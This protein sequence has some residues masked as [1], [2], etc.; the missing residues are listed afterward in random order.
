MFSATPSSTQAGG[1]PNLTVS[2]TRTGSDTE[3]L[4]DL[5]ID[6]PPGVIGNPEA[7]Q[8]CSRADFMADACPAASQVGTASTVADA[9]GLNLPTVPGSVYVL[10]PDPTEAAALGIV[11]RPPASDLGAISKVFLVNSASAHRLPNGDYALRNVS[12]NLPRQVFLLGLIPVDITVNSLTLTLNAAGDGPGKFFVTNTTNCGPEVAS[13]TAVDYN[14]QSVSKDAPYQATGCNSVPFTPGMAMSWSSTRTGALT[15]PNLTLTVPGNESPIRQSH[16]KAVTVRF[17]ASVTLDAFSALAIDT[18]SQSDFDSDSCAAGSDL[19]DALAS[20]PPLP[21]AFTGDVYRLQAQ[22]GEAFG[23][24]LWLRGP[25]GLKANLRGFS[26]IENNRIVTTFPFQPQIPFTQFTLK[27]TRNIFVN[28]GNC[29][30]ITTDATLTGWSGA[31]ANVSADT[32]VTGCEHPRSASVLN[33]PMVPNFRQ[34]ISASQC[35]ARGGTASTHGAPL[36]LASCNP[37]GYAPGTAAHQGPSSVG[38]AQYVFIPGNPDEGVDPD[39]AIGLNVSDVQDRQTGADYAPNASGPDVSLVSK[40]RITDFLN[41]PQLIDQATASD[42]DFPVP[43]ECTPTADPSVGSSCNVATSANATVF[44]SI[45][46]GA[47]TMMQMF[48]VRLNDSGSNG[49]LGDGDDRA[50]S[51]QGLYVR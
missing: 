31:V 34:T 26:T 6:L 38:S 13:V 46:S 47:A 18:C 15:A 49:V 20:V 51:Q 8:K 33:V 3:D 25:R 30:P 28:P 35:A 1:H 17:P 4:R 36:S 23:F 11:L 37:P 24:G 16:V 12:M 22:A 42:L 41:G 14:G 10:E 27:L 32:T 9:V 48:R 50:F 39:L 43:I 40:L 29:G 21:P 2:I 45:Q 44:G 7:V 5:T 19:G